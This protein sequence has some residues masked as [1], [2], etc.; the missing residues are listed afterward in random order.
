MI[1]FQDAAEIV[2]AMRGG[3]HSYDPA[4]VVET[5]RW[6]YLP[7]T[8]GWVGC[9]GYI[10]NK[11]DR[12]VNCLD[13]GF[14]LDDYFWAHDQGVFFDLVDFS[15]A[16]ETNRQLAAKLL[17]KFRRSDTDLPE[18]SGWYHESEIPDAMARQFP[19]FK[20]H[21]VWSAIPDLR[22]AWERK[23]LRFTSVLS[24]KG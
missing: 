21:W 3:E 18:D 17:V 22:K 19:T 20:R 15:F 2:K 11:H 1:T 6:W 4:K 5:E 9:A 13:S 12:Y 24:T 14:D 16:P 7:P 10:V 8:P 23:A